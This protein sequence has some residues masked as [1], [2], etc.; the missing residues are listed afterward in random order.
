MQLAEVKPSIDVVKWQKLT[1]VNIKRP[2]RQEMQYLAQN[3][4]FHP[5][6][7]DDCL[8]KVHLPKIDE[9]EDYILIILHLPVYD[10]R[11]RITSPSQVAIFLG[12]DFLVTIHSGNLKPLN[13]LLLSCQKDDKVCGEYMGQGS[14]YL[15]YR[16]VDALVDYCFPIVDKILSNL[17]KIED[18]V[19]DAKMD[20]AR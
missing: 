8:S 13:N 3:Y 15:L 19:L 6:A 20:V 1:W 14:C 11:T 17:A 9:Y 2:G 12:K 7:L 16:I 5:H 10:P 18:K 4:S